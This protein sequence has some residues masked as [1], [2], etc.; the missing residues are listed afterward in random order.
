MGA[1]DAP[2]FSLFLMHATRTPEAKGRYGPMNAPTFSTLRQPR[3]KPAR[4]ITAAS[5]LLGSCFHENDE[6][7][8]SEREALFFCE[9]LAI[10]MADPWGFDGFFSA[11]SERFNR[12][13]NAKAFN[14]LKRVVDVYG[15]HAQTCS[16][17]ASDQQSWSVSCELAGDAGSYV[18]PV[19]SILQMLNGTP[20]YWQTDA[21]MQAQHV[22]LFLAPDEY[23]VLGRA[24]F[25]DASKFSDCTA[26]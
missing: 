25:N 7:A 22:L 1:R 5:I 11:N 8:F 16:E 4:L 17:L 21:G 18:T 6:P 12:G 15:A 24:Q 20:S 9:S 3:R 26:I 10:A 14:Y 2:L 19:L 13:Y 23:A